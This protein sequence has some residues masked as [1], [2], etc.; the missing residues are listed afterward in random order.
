MMSNIPTLTFLSPDAW[1]VIFMV[2]IAACYIYFVWYRNIK[3]MR[4]PN[5]KNKGL[6][7]FLFIVFGVILPI[8]FILINVFSGR[9]RNSSIQ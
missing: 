7:I 4:D 5:G 8:Y 6:S 3:N 1:S 2:I 9:K